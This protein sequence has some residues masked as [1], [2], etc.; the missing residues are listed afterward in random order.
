[1][2]LQLTA[3][4]KN[5]LIFVVEI[6]SRP[7]AGRIRLLRCGALRSKSPLRTKTPHLPVAA[8]YSDKRRKLPPDPCNA[9]FTGGQF[10]CV[11]AAWHLEYGEGVDRYCGYLRRWQVRDCSLLARRS[12]ARRSWCARRLARA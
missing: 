10:Q 3:R 2:Y 9:P 6:I 8:R 4:R 11:E 5:S 12:R 1:M 7:D